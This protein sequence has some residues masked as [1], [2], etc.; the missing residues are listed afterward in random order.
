[1]TQQA[2]APS[3]K[4]PKATDGLDHFYCHDENLSH[5][6]LDITDLPEVADMPNLCVVCDDLD[7]QPCE[8]CEAI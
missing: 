1:M 8:E 2:I 4:P 3:I 7:R 6:G 5:C